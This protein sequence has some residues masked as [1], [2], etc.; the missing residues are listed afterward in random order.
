MISEGETIQVLGDKIQQAEDLV[1]TTWS[2]IFPDVFFFRETFLI[3]SS[4]VKIVQFLK[5]LT[6]DHSFKK[7][8]W[9]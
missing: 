5:I 6:M 7:L 3:E 1:S 9:L 8:C 4:T 2:I